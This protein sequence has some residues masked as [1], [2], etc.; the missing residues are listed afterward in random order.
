M[1]SSIA[2]LNGVLN[3]LL[4]FSCMVTLLGSVARAALIAC[5]IISF[6]ALTLISTWSGARAGPVLVTPPWRS[7]RQAQPRH[8]DGTQPE[9]ARLLQTDE[10]AV[11]QLGQA[12]QLAAEDGE[13]QTDRLDARRVGAF[14]CGFAVLVRQPLRQEKG[15]HATAEAVHETIQVK[16]VP[17]LPCRTVECLHGCDDMISVNADRQLTL[18]H[19]LR[20]EEQ[21]VLQL[22]HVHGRALQHTHRRAMTTMCDDV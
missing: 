9:S 10:H 21:T 14:D 3:A 2:L 17:V 20:S 5:T 22:R 11:L 19:A 15:E 8:V 6:P 18:W 7:A 12:G 1:A 13:Y 16:L 4:Q